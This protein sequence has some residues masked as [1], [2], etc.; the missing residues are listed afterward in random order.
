MF[1]FVVLQRISF[2]FETAKWSQ[3]DRLLTDH[4]DPFT[5]GHTKKKYQITIKLKFLI[6]NFF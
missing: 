4:C 5:N 2:A 1:Y 3:G 6:S